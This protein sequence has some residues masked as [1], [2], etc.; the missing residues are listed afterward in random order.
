M[1]DIDGEKH[2]EVLST[3]GDTFLG[4]EDFDQRIINFLV[5]EFKKDQGLDLAMT[6]WLFRDSRKLQKRQKLSFHPL[7]RLKLV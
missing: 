3:N 6:L 2:F 7:S 5:D 4:G 1:E